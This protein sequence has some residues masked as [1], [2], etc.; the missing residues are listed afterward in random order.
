MKDD[1]GR[2]E[3][4]TQMANDDIT[5]WGDG[6]EERITGS[7]QIRYNQPEKCLLMSLIDN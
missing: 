4:V 3:E 5:H 1:F 7:G 6:R 2:I